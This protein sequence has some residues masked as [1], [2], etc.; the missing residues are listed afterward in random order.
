MTEDRVTS[1]NTKLTDPEL[2]MLDTT[3]KAL[4]IRTRAGAVRR[5][6]TLLARLAA[7]PNA[8]LVIR[9]PDGSEATIV[10]L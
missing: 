8:E 1:V 4:G 2:D 10:F 3:A 7:Y 9:R 5:A 6:I